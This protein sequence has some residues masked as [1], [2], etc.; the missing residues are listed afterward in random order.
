MLIEDRARLPL[1]PA[2][3][4]SKW[5]PSHSRAG[6]GGHGCQTSPQ[7]PHSSAYPSVRSPVVMRVSLMVSVL[8]QAGQ[9]ATRRR[10]G[11]VGDGGV[12]VVADAV[13]AAPVPGGGGVGVV[14]RDGGVAALAAAEDVDAAGQAVLGG[15]EVLVADDGF[16]V[17]Q[18]GDG[19][20]RV[21]FCD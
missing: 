16:D 14:G 20:D 2:R 3:A 4:C 10:G 11:E 13:G 19:H 7:S 9:V 1:V 17:I 8:P 5:R 15:V 12:A 18:D 6:G 21:S